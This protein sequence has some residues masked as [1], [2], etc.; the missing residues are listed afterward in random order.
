MNDTVLEMNG[1]S[2][3]FGGVAALSDVSI[4]LR[5]GEILAIVGENGAGKSTLMKVLSGSYPAG[6]YTGTI[7]IDGAEQRFASPADSEKAGIAMIYQE[8]S[9]H[10]DASI[11]ENIF[12]GNLP[13]AS[14]VINWKTVY[15]KARQYTDMV[16]LNVPV[17]QTLRKLSASQQ[18]LVAIARALSRNPRFLVL[19]EPTSTLTESEADVLFNILFRLKE[20]GISSIYISHK[21][22][23]VLYLAD[24]ITILR[25][26]RKISTRQI[27]ETSIDLTVEEMV[28]R[29]I[30]EMYPKRAVPIGEEVFRVENLEVVHPLTNSKLIVDGVGFSVRSGE[31][32]GLVG[33]VGSGRS[34]TVNAIFGAIRR[35]SGELFLD[36]RP[37]RI[38][39]PR[40]AIRSGLALLTEDRKKDGFVAAFNVTLNATLARFRQLARHSVIDRRREESAASEYVDKINIKLRDLRDNILQLSGGNQQKVVLSKWLMTRP[41]VLFLDEP[42]RGIDV[43]AKAQIYELICDLAQEGIAVVMISSELPELV[44]MCDRFVVLSEGKV[45]AERQ[46]GEAD[47]E[48]LL[49]LA[50]LGMG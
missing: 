7:R 42:T 40:D 43:G 30:D 41:R 2:K 13:N 33:L 21:L 12:L 50:T 45:A 3:R 49:R 47:E 20:R 6:S 9:M 29:K 5:E 23:E 37:V 14:G 15:E 18:Q 22:K 34:E 10:L 28:N 25:D 44:G 4:D 38:R 17:R 36:G 39:N 31:I 11:A 16:G 48:A 8:I 27:A 19:D 32:L 35:K 1:I 24:R 26:G 46:R